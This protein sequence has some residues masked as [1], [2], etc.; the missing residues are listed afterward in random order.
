[1]KDDDIIEEKWAEY[2]IRCVDD[3]PRHTL[4]HPSNRNDALKQLDRLNSREDIDCGPHRLV[5]RLVT[6]QSYPFT[7]LQDTDPQTEAREALINSAL[8]RPCPKC[9]EES[10]QVC[11]NLSV[12]KREGVKDPT[13]WPHA[14]RF[15]PV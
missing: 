6:K 15:A 5:Q 3:H 11:I 8:S 12:W 9:K 10:G 4:S 14:E 2:R 13:A 7:E 1:M